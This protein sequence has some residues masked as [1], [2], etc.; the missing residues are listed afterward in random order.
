MSQ[1]EGTIL[2]DPVTSHMR[3]DACKI[4]AGQTVE[5]VLNYL[6]AHP[7]AGRIVYLYV[8]DA[9]DRLQGVLP[10]RRLLLSASN[11]LVDSIM[12][13]KVVTVP[14]TA[15]VLDACEFFTMHKLLAFPVLNA[16]RKFIGIVDVE[17]YT[18]ELEDLDQHETTEDVFQLIGVHL[19]EAE[20]KTIGPAV[21]RRFP[22]L[23]CNVAGGLIAGLLTD[24]YSDVSTLAIVTPFIPLVLALGESVAIQ[25]VSL[26][27]QLLHGTR[28]TWKLLRSSLLREAAIGLCL[29]LGC[30]IIVGIIAVGWKGAIS[31]GLSLLGGIAGG[32]FG[33]AVIGMA[34]PIVMRLA[35]RD[36][37][38]ASGPIALACADI[39]SLV[40]YFTLARAL[41]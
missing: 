2:N 13:K 7:P 26:A 6:R 10:T 12:V 5:E 25:S 9:E 36:P 40:I 11:T 1:L 27:I 15:T 23:L 34:L 17:L 4:L 32:V 38:V 19:T 28:P 22:W 16:E 30:G 39:V 31:V 20:L 18:G 37:S 41:L 14:H 8:V 33:A 24:I 35:K 21:R 29:G 3:T